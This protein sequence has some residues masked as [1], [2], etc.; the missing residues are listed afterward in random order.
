MYA[1]YPLE[2]YRDCGIASYNLST[3]NQSIEASYYLVKESIEKDHPSLI[4]MDC[5]MAWTDK[6]TMEPQ[7][8]HYITDT[9]PYLSKNRIEMIKNLSEEGEE[10]LPLLFPLIAYHN[11][12]QEL[13]YEDAMP[14]AKE[15]IYGCKVNSRIEEAVPFDAPEEVEGVR[16]PESSVNYLQ[17]I[18]DLCNEN[19]TQ[20]LLMHIPAL[21]KNKF[22]GQSGF[23]YRWTAAQ[24]VKKLAE[25]NNVPYLD[26]FAKCQEMGFDLKREASDGEHLNRW[27][28]TRFTGILGDYIKENYDL[29]DRRGTGGAYDVIDKDAERYPISRL[30]DSLHRSLFLRDY[31]ATLRSDAGSEKG[32]EVKDALIMIA[33]NG[34][35]DHEILKSEQAELLKGIGLEQD[36]SKL[37]GHS[38]LAV[39]DGGKIIYETVPGEEDAADSYEGIAGD[40][41]YTVASGRV[42]EDTGRIRSHAS[43]RVNGLEYTTDNRGL[44]F[45]VFDKS[46]GELLDACWINIF[47]QAFDCTHDNH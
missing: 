2:L 13:T 16:L 40:L 41:H 7:Y 14:Q 34:T 9:M 46:S 3:G 18:I 1:I 43:I 35:V 44:H 47:S 8:I 5:N 36:L 31:A 15:M 42:E 20:L 4:V 32:E 30:R 6:E 26:Y 45:A 25:K 22:F 23:N 33:L 29:P 10:K 12:W 27:G 21:G 11:R 38:W 39:I 24:E 37:E 19:G 28:A 17:K